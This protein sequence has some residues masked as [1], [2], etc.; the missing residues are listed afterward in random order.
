VSHEAVR[1]SP[2][3]RLI[4]ISAI[5]LYAEGLARAVAGEPELDVCGTADDARAATRMLEAASPPIDVAVL[6]LGLREGIAGARL[7]RACRQPPRV[8]ALGLR[9]IDEDVI[10]WAE[11]G[12][13][14]FVSR[15]AT[16]QELIAT[17]LSVGR[18]ESSCSPPMVA[19]LLRRVADVAHVRVHQLGA[20]PTASLTVRE[21]E[22]VHLI[23]EGLSNKEIA[24][25]LQIELPTVK[26]HVHHALDKLAVS[27]RADAA[28]LVRERTTV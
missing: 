7:V 1:V 24:A 10:G 2:V 26:N 4:I 18:G 8:V 13:S 22:I 3:I 16:L 14:G 15:Q 12:A 19:A 6:D 11:A 9:E 21:R 25:R 5:R 23:D 27:R 17:V 28:A 20:D